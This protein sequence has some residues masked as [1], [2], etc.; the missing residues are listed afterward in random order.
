MRIF[1]I[2]FSSVLGILVF[3][4][5]LSSYGKKKPNILFCLADDWGLF[6]ASI[7]G[8]PVIETPSFDRL[9]KEGVL[10]T[11]AFVNSPTCT[12]SRAGILSG[13]MP[14][15]LK[16]AIN[17]S[18]DW[19]SI[20]PLYTDLLSDNGFLVGFTG[21]GWAP[22]INTGRAI[23]PA[24]RKYKDF[25]EFLIQR[26]KDQPFCFWFG[27]NSPHR[28]YNKDLRNQYKI[29][30]SKINIPAFLPDVDE[31]RNDLADYYAEVKQ[32]DNEVGLL[33]QKLD[34]IGELDNTIIVM[35][36]DNGLPFPRGKGNLYL[37]GIKAP[38]AIKWAKKCKP[39]RVVTDFI[40]FTDFAPTFLEAAEIKIPD[41]MTGKS[42]LNLLL[43]DKTGRIDPTRNIV[44]AERERH[45]WCQP[46]GKS[47]PVRAVCNEDY[48]YIRNFRPYLFPAGDPFLKRKNSTPLGHVDCDEGP[49]KYFI[50]QNKNQPEYSKF[51]KLCF[52]LRPAEELYDL[53]KDPLQLTNLADRDSERK[54]LLE[55]RECLKKW[56]EETNDPRAKGETTIWDGSC[57]HAQARADEKIVH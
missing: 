29:N 14:H 9:A 52:D 41:C 12:A 6:P 18:S 35:T 47:F 38:L 46:E 33:L 20:P 42:F 22:G 8:D 54:T 37:H 31:V 57:W 49:S 44:F 50:I 21:K 55:M 53:R 25:S 51:Y 17:L 43:S 39:D 34:S 13:Q 36:G 26:K 15:R 24:G 5:N 11:N 32:F 30:P 10:F 28:P 45:T 2:I 23:N 1:K 3:A 40:S 4:F 16:N 56:M 27:S 7:P 48:L 19:L